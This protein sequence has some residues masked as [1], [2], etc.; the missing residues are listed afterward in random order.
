MR[1]HVDGWL[2]ALVGL[3]L[4]A[5]LALAFQML[6]RLDP[7]TGDEPF[8]VL[9][10]I[11]IIRDGDLD[12]SNNFENRDY[13]EFYP[14]QPLPDAWNGWPAFPRTL[15]PHPATTELDGLHT[16]HGLGLSLLIALPYEVAGRAGAM[17]VVLI[18]AVL[19]AVN[20]YLLAREERA[21][22]AWAASISAMLAL[23]MPIAPYAALLFPEIPSA[24][25]LIYAIRRLASH[26]NT[27]LTLGLTGT[28]IGLLPWLHQR[29]V[30]TVLILVVFALM[31]L[32]RTRDAT[33]AVVTLVPIVLGG[34]A[35][36]G[37]NLW[38]YG[39]PIQNTADHAGFNGLT[40][41]V[42]AGF[43]LLLDAQWGLLIAAPI[44]LLAIA[45]IPQWY[46][47]SYVARLALA[48]LLPYVLVIAT[49]SVWWGEWGPP[50]R[51]LV[52]IAPFAAGALAVLIAGLTTR[53]I[54]AVIGIWGVGMVLTLVGVANPQRFYHH[55]NGINN[56]FR[57]MDNWF[58]TQTANW[59]VAY[60]PIAQSSLYQRAIVAI[61]LGI[62][63]TVCTRWMRRCMSASARLNTQANAND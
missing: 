44:Y 51:Y 30:P 54:V 15:P 36:V 23:S 1:V 43:G 37:Y 26:E 21:S 28:S 3:V 59:L 22:P 5:Y 57:V 33:M 25:L 52:P 50:A 9:T 18:C 4:V 34:F 60:Q 46:R 7:L 42:N 56:I 41:T 8:Y 49:Y 29:F 13:D 16:K 10:A 12:E 38:L 11:S 53:G 35:L 31:K 45:G 6:D 58:G 61:V 2:I 14:A 39:R 40:E 27:W 32:W 48:A 63:L 17:L 62:A 55:P 47:V 20:M 24:L 19:V